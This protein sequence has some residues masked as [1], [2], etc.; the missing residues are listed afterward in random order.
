VLT[1]WK[2]ATTLVAIILLILFSIFLPVVVNA[3]G[4]FSNTRL[5]PMVMGGTFILKATRIDTTNARLQTLPADPT[6]A[7]FLFGSATLQGLQILAPASGGTTL[8]LTASGSTS[9]TNVAIKT[10]VGYELATA[11]ASF[12]NKADLVVLSA[13]GT[14]SQ[15]SMVN[16]SLVIDTYLQNGTLTISGFHLAFSASSIAIPAAPNLSISGVV[17][18]LT[19]KTCPA[20]PGPTC[21]PTATPKP[22][23]P[24]SKP[25]PGST[26]KADPTVPATA[27][28]MSSP[29]ATPTPVTPTPASKGMVAPDVVA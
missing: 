18:T 12:V 19:P 27:T 3:Q 21:T 6:H 1:S 23:T 2:S 26:P 9:A 28:P 13:G 15:L 22:V 8:A 16:V 5:F 4:T 10:L 11:L 7:I 29:A 24:G 20:T 25:K 17:G 14:V